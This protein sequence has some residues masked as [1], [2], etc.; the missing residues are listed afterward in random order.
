MLRP[1]LE[2]GFL[3]HLSKLVLLGLLGIFQ[4]LRVVF[5]IGHC[6]ALVIMSVAQ[7][8]TGC[9]RAL[10]RLLLALVAGG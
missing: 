5:G 2:I 10:A 4:L 3:D 7:D 1:I 9:P 6:Q 8:D